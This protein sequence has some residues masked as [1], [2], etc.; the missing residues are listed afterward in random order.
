MPMPC[1]MKPECISIGSIC[2]VGW[3]GLPKWMFAFSWALDNWIIGADSS[4]H[5]DKDRHHIFL[6]TSLASNKALLFLNPNFTIS[7]DL[8]GFT[9]LAKETDCPLSIVV[10]KAIP[11]CPCCVKIGSTRICTHKPGERVVFP[12]CL[13]V[14]TK[15]NRWH[16]TWPRSQPNSPT[17][18]FF[19]LSGVWHP[20]QVPF[21]FKSHFLRPAQS[22]GVKPTQVSQTVQTFLCVSSLMLPENW[23]KW[24]THHGY[25]LFKCAVEL[26]HT[27]DWRK[28]GI[29]MV[30]DVP[31]DTRDVQDVVIASPFSIHVNHNFAPTWNVTYTLPHSCVFYPKYNERIWC[32][33]FLVVTT[34]SGTTF[35]FGQSLPLSIVV[36]A[37]EGAV[38]MVAGVLWHFDTEAP[39][40]TKV[41]GGP[42][43]TDWKL[44][45][46]AFDLCEN[47][48]VH[49]IYCISRFWVSNPTK[50]CIDYQY[51]MKEVFLIHPSFWTLN[52]SWRSL[53]MFWN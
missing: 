12:V 24:W 48:Y 17:R 46:F 10:R 8:R 5:F 27:S 50:N 9:H 51:Q 49:V 2:E 25:A 11:T 1:I 42:G 53:G 3:S 22:A 18:T 15:K 45:P 29:E 20:W 39:P 31:Y 16:T 44:Q 26:K 36:C 43:Q 21:Y 40:K 4:K 52:K 19:A 34:H 35:P 14:Y 41:E 13:S 6:V 32:G 37:S 23:L 28:K 30:N 33:T 7:H 47:M 38:H